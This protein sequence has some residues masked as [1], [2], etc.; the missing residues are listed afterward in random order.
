M[1]CLPV[2]HSAYG[3]RK[4]FR[5]VDRT[6]YPRLKMLLIT[7]PRSVSYRQCVKELA[8]E[9]IVEFETSKIW[10]HKETLVHS[11]A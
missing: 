3:D 2:S 8:S 5:S 11:E 4:D 1:T 7:R 6:G 10:L 9:E